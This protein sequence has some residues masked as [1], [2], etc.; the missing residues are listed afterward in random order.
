MPFKFAALDDVIVASASQDPGR[1]MSGGSHLLLSIAEMQGKK[2]GPVSAVKTPYASGATQG[3]TKAYGSAPH[4]RSKHGVSLINPLSSTFDSTK[5]DSS[6]YITTLSLLESGEHAANSYATARSLDRQGIMRGNTAKTINNIDANRLLPQTVSRSHGNA[7][8]QRAPASIRITPAGTSHLNLQT[9][10]GDY[11]IPQSETVREHL[12]SGHISSHTAAGTAAAVAAHVA[13]QR[14]PVKVSLQLPSLQGTAITPVVATQFGSPQ[15]LSKQAFPG[16]TMDRAIRSRMAIHSATKKSHFREQESDK[17]KPAKFH[18]SP[19]QKPPMTL[20]QVI[21]SIQ[22]ESDQFGATELESN[23]KKLYHTANSNTEEDML[24]ELGPDVFLLNTASTELGSQQPEMATP[25]VSH[26]VEHRE[27]SPPMNVDDLE[28]LE[29][30]ETPSDQSRSTENDICLS[31]AFKTLVRVP[32]TFDSL[33]QPIESGILEPN[34]SST[35]LKLSSITDPAPLNT[36]V[37]ESKQVLKKK[38]KKSVRASK[39]SSLCQST[40]PENGSHEDSEQLKSPK[41][42]Q[43]STLSKDVSVAS[44]DSQFLEHTNP[45]I[46]THTASISIRT[47]SHR[48][49]TNPSSLQ[50]FYCNASSLAVP[51]INPTPVIDS[52]SVTTCIAPTPL[53]V[54]ELLR[55]KHGPGGVG[56]GAAVKIDPVVDLDVSTDTRASSMAPSVDLATSHYKKEMS[57]DKGRKNHSF[58]DGYLAVSKHVA[59]KESVGYPEQ[60]HKSTACIVIGQS[61]RSGAHDQLFN[62]PDWAISTTGRPDH[63]TSYH[64]TRRFNMKPTPMRHRPVDTVSDRLAWT[65]GSVHT[66][67]SLA[68]VD[69]FDGHGTWATDPHLTTASDPEAYTITINTTTLSSIFSS[70]IRSMPWAK[71]S[72]PHCRLSLCENRSLQTPLITRRTSSAPGLLQR[73]YIN[74]LTDDDVHP[75]PHDST[76]ERVSIFYGTGLFKPITDVKLEKIRIQKPRS[77][78]GSRTDIQKCIQKLQVSDKQNIYTEDL[79]RE[80][81]SQSFSEPRKLNKN[82]D[83]L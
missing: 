73:C 78:T 77:V 59:G 16:A 41:R 65:E 23:E 15:H 11:Q 36:S 60:T 27:I 39:L 48:N 43:S 2:A 20:K 49:A 82:S 47:E 26:I 10:P 29:R 63:R 76:S 44:T 66:V 37:S 67:S 35:A 72:P 28:P 55:H 3:Y 12:R 80:T 42:L 13:T 71:P 8:S 5:G 9:S 40:A 18:I 7:L 57:K 22:T 19:P 17:E 38:Q 79:P 4:F 6:S 50:T 52:E 56:K 70:P 25:S 62:P 69:A 34:K 1:S 68:S 45:N 30:G 54:K 83:S 64:S 31:P 81:K 33:L 51:Q 61:S 75:S 21:E 74:D 53:S 46:G 32:H 24:S 14:H 58:S